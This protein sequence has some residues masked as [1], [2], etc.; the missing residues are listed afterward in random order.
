[1]QLEQQR[2][3]MGAQNIAKTPLA[4]RYIGRLNDINDQLCFGAL[5]SAE[6]GLR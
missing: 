3:K 2:E 5:S 6:F 4:A 1:M